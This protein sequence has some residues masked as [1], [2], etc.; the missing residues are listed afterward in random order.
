MSVAFEG[1][2]DLLVLDRDKDKRVTSISSGAISFET[3]DA[4]L[5]IENLRKENC[6]GEE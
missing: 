3:L 2:G 1:L 4:I 5:Q 6:E